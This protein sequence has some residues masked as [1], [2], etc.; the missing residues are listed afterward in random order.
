[1]DVS[2]DDVLTYQAPTEGKH[3]QPVALCAVGRG[4][5]AGWAGGG[6]SLHVC[7]SAGGCWMECHC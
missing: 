4:R 6:R 2:P 1:M 7:R 5:E 3:E